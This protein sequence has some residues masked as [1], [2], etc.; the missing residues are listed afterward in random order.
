MTALAVMRASLRPQH[1]SIERALD[2]MSGGVDLP[3]YVRFIE[4]SYGF[5]AACERRLDLSRAPAPLRAEQRLKTP[6]LRT[7]L[8][9]LGNN[10]ASIDR[11]PMCEQLPSVS[12]WPHA[13]GYFYV[14][15]GSTLGGQ[16]L[17]RRLRDRLGVDDR[18]LAFLSAYGSNTGTMWKQM[19]SVLESAMADEGAATVI[20]ASARDTFTLLQRWHE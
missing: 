1:D 13:L 3:R 2:L 15:E 16:L 4:R 6:L 17:S 18:G 5:I 8:M 20:T 12:E 9:A 14:I 7:N 19:L 10:A 11:L